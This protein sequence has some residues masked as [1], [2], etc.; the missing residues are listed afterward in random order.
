MKDALERM[1]A[2]GRDDALLRF[3]LGNAYLSEG[4]ALCAASHFEA[5]VRHN[6]DYSA[7]WK[8]LGKAYAQASNFDQAEQ[9]YKNGIASA[10]RNGDLQAV[11]EMTVFARRVSRLKQAPS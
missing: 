3:S 1:L 2:K 8:L 11:K 7:A 10:T 4:D 5:A 6:P 9:A